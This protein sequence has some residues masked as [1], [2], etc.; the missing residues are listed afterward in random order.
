MRSSPNDAFQSG[1]LLLL[2]TSALGPAGI[3]RPG[4]QGQ[5]SFQVDTS[6]VVTRGLAVSLEYETADST[7][8][9]D[10]S[11]LEPTL[12]PAT[13]TDTQWNSAFARIQ[14]DAGSTWG[15]FIKYASR[16]AT[17]LGSQGGD[18]HSA[19]SVFA[20][21]VGDALSRTNG[22]VQGHVYQSDTS[23]PLAGVRIFFQ[24][25]TN[26]P[27]G[28]AVT[29]ADG[30]YDAIIGSPGTFEAFV[31]NFI[32]P[33]PTSVT[34]GPAL[35]GSDGVDVIVEPENEI[36]G[37]VND[38]SDGHP[39]GG[40]TVIA[41]GPNGILD[42]ATDAFGRYD[43]RGLPDG[44]YSLIAGGDPFATA[45]VDG[46]QVSDH[47]TINGENF[48]LAPGATLHGTVTANGSPLA[49]ADVTLTDPNGN[50]SGV[51]SDSQGDYAFD[52]LAPGAYTIQ[53]F[54]DPFALGQATVTLAAGTDTTAPAITLVAGATISETVTDPSSSP[55]SLATV[56]LESADGSLQDSFATGQDGTLGI[57]DI[58]AGDYFLHTVAP[59]FL[60]SIK[61]ITLVSGATLSE[62]IA[63][64]PAATIKG[65]VV[66]SSSSP[67][68]GI[69][70]NVFGSNATSDSYSTQ[71]ITASD[72]TYSVGSLPLGTYLVTVGNNLGILPDPITISSTAS[73][74]V[75]NFTI[76]GATLS[77]TVFAGDGATPAGGA[78][79]ELIVS[80]QALATAVTDS[81]GT[82][83][84]RDLKPGSYDVRA[85]TSSGIG[86]AQG[87]VVSGVASFTMNLISAGNLT[88]AGSVSD[89]QGN[90]IP[91]ATLA[92]SPDDGSGEVLFA[93]SDN[94]GNFSFNGLTAATYVV[95]VSADG[96][97]DRSQIV[98][99]PS[100]T[101]T[102][103]MTAGVAVSG[104]VSSASG[105]TSGASV[106]LIDP[107]SLATIATATTDSSGAFSIP[108]APLGTFDAVATAPGFQLQKLT[109]LTISALTSSLNF[110]LGAST[111][112]L[113]GTVSDEDGQPI[114]DATVQI[115]DS[116]GETVVSL[117]SA[118]DG[119]WAT[120]SLPPGAYKVGA[121]RG[122]YA[123]TS[124][125]GVSV[126]TSSPARANLALST[127][128]TDDLRLGQPLIV[129]DLSNFAEAIGAGVNFALNALGRNAT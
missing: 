49:G 28:S 59:G 117:A 4:D 75:A 46:I 116:S 42:A 38:P 57:P 76:P 65:I 93:T 26:V 73:P 71:A 23:H 88:L 69:T 27:F 68:S 114:C 41:E 80:G 5:V 29:A 30:S 61:T 108:N 51:D 50:H 120:T 62:P 124:L 94:S 34:V 58:P 9:L 66:D 70:V 24:D 113:N 115:V 19:A 129:V 126:L 83:R 84:F 112:V 104:Q 22:G 64:A 3:L 60:E 12:R 122:G 121:L 86:T 111:T 6:S 119:K 109:G 13:T 45:H 16:F 11:T 1:D 102:L 10:W 14:N 95:S 128:A 105:P 43:L 77:G 33:F 96:F 36:S 52:G 40:V 63:L 87:V 91:D 78:T 118:V 98:T 72:G 123:P 90:P 74:F 85:A 106:A 103:T 32:N 20:L 81:T 25:A 53:I 48:L 67:I 17:E 125:S 99:L 47:S 97:V 127:V 21:M 37:T 2:G 107:S 18:P 82:Y 100:S 55:I 56:V 39:L 101:I 31:P 54:D 92:I 8:P 79:V 7:E 89:V 110:N 15:T 44:T 35:Q